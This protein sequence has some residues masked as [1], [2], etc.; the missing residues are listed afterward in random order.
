MKWF[1]FPFC[2]YCCKFLV[3]QLFDLFWG[4]FCAFSSTVHL[5]RL[6]LTPQIVP[7]ALFHVP[8]DIRNWNFFKHKY[9]KTNEYTWKYKYSNAHAQVPNELNMEMEMEMETAAAATVALKMV[10]EMELELKAKSMR[11]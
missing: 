10:M 8:F 11:A 5:A 9:R 6:C 4:N 1:L 7:N 2:Y 3:K